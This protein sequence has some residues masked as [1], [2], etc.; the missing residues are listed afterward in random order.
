MM[1]KS[2]RE[3]GRES[4]HKVFYGFRRVR[5]SLTGVT[6]SGFGTALRRLD[7]AQKKSR[8]FRRL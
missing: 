6:T 8:R 5:I 3:R 1:N 4:S 2:L 7:D